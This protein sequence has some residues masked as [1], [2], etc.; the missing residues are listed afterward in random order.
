MKMKTKGMMKSSLIAA[1]VLIVILGVGLA[2]LG[3]LRKDVVAGNRSIERAENK[4]RIHVYVKLDPPP[5]GAINEIKYKL[6]EGVPTEVGVYRS[7]SPGYWL[8]ERLDTIPLEKVDE[9]T[10]YG[11][12]SVNKTNPVLVYEHDNL[13]MYDNALCVGYPGIK[14]CGGLIDGITFI[15]IDQS[16]EEVTVTVYYWEGSG[17]IPPK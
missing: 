14:Y 10:F 3:Y 12:K 7:Y 15:R 17:P 16:M 1:L 4:I 6:R 13:Q 5:E 8:Y 11:A 2:L 9:L